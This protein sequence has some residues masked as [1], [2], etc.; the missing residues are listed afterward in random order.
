VTTTTDVSNSL[1]V[2]DLHTSDRH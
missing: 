2:F 1:N